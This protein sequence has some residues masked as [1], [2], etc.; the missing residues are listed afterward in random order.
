MRAFQRMRYAVRVGSITGPVLFAILVWAAP[1]LAGSI[2]GFYG[3]RAEVV[4]PAANAIPRVRNVIQ[5]VSALEKVA[6]NRL[7]VHQD[8]A[9]AVI[10]WLSFDIGA[11]ASTHFD[12]KGEKTWTALNRIYDESPSVI[13]GRLT[14]DGRVYLLNRNGILFSPNSQ[15][16]VHTLIG[17]A[18]HMSVDDFLTRK[19]LLSPRA[20]A[21]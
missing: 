1:V 6:E 8:E 7:V 10:D 21:L 9:R 20:P 13:S 12:Q 5:G 18:L 2:P 11:N 4:P 15:V 17:S 14:A 3:T 16:N 19:N